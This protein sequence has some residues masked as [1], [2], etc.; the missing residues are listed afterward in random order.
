MNAYY[1][2]CELLAKGEILQALNRQQNW[3]DKL[4][5]Q[6]IND[7]CKQILQTYDY[8][9]SYFLENQEDPSRWE[10]R[11]KLILQAYALIDD[12]YERMRIMTNSSKEFEYLRTNV[13]PSQS[14]F[15]TIWL[16]QNWSE[17][18]R[19]EFNK[20]LLS[21]DDIQKCLAISALTLNCLRRFSENRILALFD[22]IA[23]LQNQAKERAFVGLV[24]IL[25]KYNERIVYFSRI[26]EALQMLLQQENVREHIAEILYQ[27][28]LTKKTFM[29][30]KAIEEMQQKVMQN[31]PKS[32]T[33]EQLKVVILDEN[34][35]NPKWLEKTQK[36][37]SKEM[38][39]LTNLNNEGVDV[40]YGH[41]KMSF[42]NPFFS[43]SVENW[44]TPYYQEN[45][46]LDYDFS[47]TVGRLLADI[48]KVNEMCDADKYA[49][50]FFYKQVQSLSNNMNEEQWKMVGQQF[51]LQDYTV[52]IS[53][54]K[55]AID[56]IR[57]L[58]RFFNLNNFRYNNEWD[59]LVNKIPMSY[60]FKKCEIPSALQMKIID[61]FLQVERFSIAK[62]ML[63]E[64]VKI[65][66]TLENY[67]RL[68]FCYEKTNEPKEA[69]KFYSYAELLSENDKWTLLHLSYCYEADNQRI[70]ALRTIDTLINMH[71]QKRAYLVWKSELLALMQR[72]DEYKNLLY[73]I[74]IL[75]PDFTPVKRL[76]L[77]LGKQYA[78]GLER[79]K[80]KED[81]ILDTNKLELLGVE[82]NVIALLSDAVAKKS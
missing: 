64:L 9:I 76:L 16:Q 58:F 20:I 80:N 43:N 4:Q 13:Y 77:I 62:N 5:N 39:E 59:T 72:A 45:P 51:N 49:L 24:L 71:G 27:F 65:Q 50:C 74:E 33:E 75:Y 8:L 32:A 41:L 44:F 48:L 10:V 3:M 63:S 68:G 23:Y 35:D 78:A 46:Q 70:E 53:D 69:I 37:I 54:N 2:S 30:E 81:F 36:N 52:M 7:S 29:A 6:E 28:V 73:Q 19:A 25:L 12:I 66:P 22:S 55:Y 31:L 11:N 1:D 47:S 17:D 14:L 60:L 67:Q 42:Y 56:Y 18:D 26:T 79:Y 82:Q 40:N 21:D 57:T 61:I 15:T 34:E 38:N